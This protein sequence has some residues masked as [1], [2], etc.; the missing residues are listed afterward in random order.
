VKA[1]IAAN[2]DLKGVFATNEGGAI[3]AV[4]AFKDLKMK[5]GKIKLIGFDSGAA[6][7]N[8]IKTG[9]MNG[10]ITQ[11]PIGIGYKTVAALVAKVRGGTTPKNFIDTGFYYYNAKNLTDPKIA[12]V[13]YQ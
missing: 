11:D 1:V 6:Q 12:A 5:K 7:I 2:K 9:L 4:N 13:L 10:A 3:G 8:A